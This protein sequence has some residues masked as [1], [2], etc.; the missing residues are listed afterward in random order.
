[1]KMSKVMIV[2]GLSGSLLALTS[3]STTHGKGAPVTNAAGGDD[4]GAV[5]SGYGMGA[6]F[7]GTDGA[8]LKAPSNQSYYYDYNSNV[9]HQKYD[10]SIQAQGNY[11]V[12]HPNARVRLEG[13]CDNRGSR[14]Y[15]IALGWRRANA[16]KTVLMQD[17]VSPKQ[18]TTFSW[19]SEKPVAFGNNETA[20]AKNRRTDL[21]YKAY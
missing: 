2:L 3:C 14:E 11:L 18:I 19:G 9:V 8:S 15:N 21:I 20:W 17:G 12:A 16:V 1:M 4:N 5:T 7:N 13:N 6:G 10:P